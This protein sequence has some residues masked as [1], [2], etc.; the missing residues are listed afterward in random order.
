MFM[1][2]VLVPADTKTL[3]IDLK[4]DSLSVC[5]VMTSGILI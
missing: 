2:Q 5:T 4:K 1:N 3:K